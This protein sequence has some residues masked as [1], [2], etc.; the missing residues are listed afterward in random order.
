MTRL[1]ATVFGLMVA[2]LFPVVA[3]AGMTMQHNE[4]LVRDSRN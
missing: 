3:E 1:I 4:T 2:A